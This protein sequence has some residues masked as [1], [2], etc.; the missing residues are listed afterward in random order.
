MLGEF[1]DAGFVVGFT[2]DHGMSAKQQPDG[3]PRVI[4][5]EDELERLGIREY[6]VVLPITDPYVLHHGALGSFAWV[7]LPKVDREWR[8][9]VRGARLVEEVYGREEAAVFFETGRPDRRP[10]GGVRR[11]DG[12]RQGGRPPDD[13]SL[14]ATGLRCMRA[15]RAGRPDRREPPPEPGYAA[16]SGRGAS[17][18]LSTSR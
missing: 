3:T 1:L 14:V 7:Y 11:P 15:G 12:A 9:G 18:D 10:L 13:L 4:Y 8:G 2:A 6:H 5:L 17:R 16:G